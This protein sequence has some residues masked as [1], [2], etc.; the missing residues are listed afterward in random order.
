M[1]GKHAYHLHGGPSDFSLSDCQSLSPS[2]RRDPALTLLSISTDEPRR[3]GRTTKGQHT[4]NTNAPDEPPAKRS[5]GRTKQSKAEQTLSEVEVE[6]ED[7][8]IRCVCGAEEDDGGRMMICCDN[9]AVWQHNDCMGITEKVDELPEKYLCEQCDR[10]THGQ[11]LLAI[12][13]GEKPWEERAKERARVEEEERKARRR[14]GG[15]RGK[16]AR[17]SRQSEAGVEAR[18]GGDGSH[19]E[20]PSTP[21][22]QEGPPSAGPSA[23][24][25]NGNAEVG[26]NRRCG[27]SC[28]G[29]DLLSKT[30]PMEV[31]TPVQAGLPFAPGGTPHGEKRRQSQT[32]ASNNVASKRRKS[33]ATV[34]ATNDQDLSAERRKIVDHLVKNLSD[35]ITASSRRG[36]FKIAEGETVESLANRHASSIEQALTSHYGSPAAYSER[37][38]SILFNVKR[39]STLLHR[40]LQGH[41]T[42]DELSTMSSDEMASEEL[43]RQ[44]AAMKEEAD[45]Q[46]VLVKEEGP[47]IRKTHK[48]EEVIE[49]ESMHHMAND[50]SYASA[51]KQDSKNPESSLANPSDT[52]FNAA[53]SVDAKTAEDTTTSRRPLHIETSS[54]THPVGPERQSSGGFDLSRVWDSAHSPGNDAHRLLQKRPRR[55]SS[56]MPAQQTPGAGDDAE[57]DR[58]LKDEENESPPYSP[59]TFGDPSVV[60]SG[61][62]VMSS[63]VDASVVARFVAGGDVGQR[64]P[65]ADLIP[66]MLH[67]SG[68]IATDRANEYVCSLRHSD[69]IDVSVLSL[70]LSGEANEGSQIDKLF[71]Y[72]HDRQRYGVITELPHPSLK[73]AYIV[74]VAAG[75]APLPPFVQLLEQCSV[76]E[77]RSQNMILLTLIV[78]MRT[79]P[80]SA[81]ATPR[82]QFGQHQVAALPAAA[83]THDRFGDQRRQ[84]VGSGGP[85]MSPVTGYSGTPATAGGYTFPVHTPTYG[86]S[87]PSPFQA[88]SQQQLHPSQPPQQLTTNPSPAGSKPSP[89]DILGPFFT[90]PVVTHLLAVSPDMTELQLRNLRDLLE[91][92]PAARDDMSILQI[93]LQRLSK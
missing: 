93:Q 14:K 86:A 54:S 55:D 16:S 37:F 4:K 36:T 92:Y 78:K 74:P 12:A 79:P 8:L 64:I 84:F 9:C 89:A 60:W 1:S 56:G 88:L 72:L 90:T 53:Q 61:R 32:D 85:L 46:A 28:L 69:S 35:L 22:A 24:Q 91:Q 75:M 59:T 82:E 19:Q 73:D 18:G 38:R 33:S 68:R 58:L 5:R 10:K 62:L 51:A 3:S 71:S 52:V 27:C 49:D 40:F 11:L 67:I 81:A 47:R 30:T 39:N 42:P 17:P 80:A 66:R 29:A 83:S 48:G 57:I 25:E 77:P 13:R 7:A 31:E 43:Q 65:W 21:I 20:S 63:I 76:E 23:A 45:K 34:P 41:I 70:T 50:S 26:G 2:L 6:D 15:K 44:M 87:H